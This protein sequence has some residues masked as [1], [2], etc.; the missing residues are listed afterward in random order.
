MTKLTILSTEEQHAFDS[1]PKFQKIDKPRYFAITPEIR[2]LG[3]NNLRTPVNRVG[4]VLQLGYFRASGKFF[5]ADKFRKR[6]IQYV[7]KLLKIDKK[8]DIQSYTKTSRKNHRDTILALSGW[9]L[10]EEADDEKIKSQALWFIEQQ[11]AP[12]KVLKALV[13]FCWNRKL[14]IPSYSKL[15]GY[16]TD[17]FNHYEEQL[18]DILKREMKVDQKEILRILF[19][20]EETKRPLPRPPITNLNFINQSVK[21]SDIQENVNIFELVKGYHD[22]LSPLTQSLKLTDQA[23]EYF[24]AWV[25]KAQTFQL[26][27][28]SS[29]YKS[30]LYMLAYIKHQFYMRQDTLV[31]ILLKSTLAAKSQLHAQLQKV[32]KQE[33]SIRNTAIKSVSKS[34]KDL[35]HFANEVINIVSQEPL[36]ESEKI[37]QLEI[38]VENHLKSYDEKE[39]DRIQK[40]ETYLDDLTGNDRYFDI[41]ESLSLRLQRRVSNIIKSIDFS[42][43]STNTRLLSA[44]EH[45]KLTD[46]DVGH[47]PPLDFL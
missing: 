33:Q 14:V 23:T 9:T 30:Y 6:D 45:F 20:P 3:Y 29:P 38:L 15:S 47:N 18:L 13:E 11:L 41:L 24:A 35:T 40:M 31:D 25:Q 37:R 7:C 39:R 16:I 8:I 17:H 19:K 27:S 22:E 44:I 32:E 42:K 46:G 43:R 5:V 12:R 34:N 26:V 2:Q 28:F 1:P 21:P 36:T 4:F 10:S